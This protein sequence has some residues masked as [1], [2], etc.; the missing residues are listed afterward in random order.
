MF[1]IAAPFGNYIKPKG[2]IPVLGTFT[3]YPRPGR[4]KQIVKTLRYDFRRGGWKNDIG[5]RNPGMVVGF[6]KWKHGEII[7]LAGMTE[8]EWNLVS[9]KVPEYMDIEI[10][11][12]CPNINNTKYGINPILNFVGPLLDRK[13]TWTIAKLSPFITFG[14]IEHL[15]D[16]GIRQFHFS[17]TLPISKGGLSGKSLMPYNERLIQFTKR[18]APMSTIIAGG[19]IT[20]RDD[21]NFYSDC[22]ADHHSLGTICF[23]PL[24]LRRLIK[25]NAI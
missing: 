7:S 4:F 23:N 5:L 6:H 11:L 21:V 18:I 3:P 25:E 17:N 15:C 20:C 12:S 13:R 24:A 19:G 22:G 16:L 2:T 8:E 1:F 9:Q 10:N 14:E